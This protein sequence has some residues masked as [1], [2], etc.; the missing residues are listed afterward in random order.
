MWACKFHSSAATAHSH[1]SIVVFCHVPI[2]LHFVP[3]LWFQSSSFQSSQFHTALTWT[4]SVSSSVILQQLL[5]LLVLLLPTGVFLS[6]W[7]SV[8]CALKPSCRGR[9]PGRPDSPA[10]L[11]AGGWSLFWRPSECFANLLLPPSFLTGRFRA[12]LLNT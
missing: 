6:F 11:A 5:R 12:T 9:V 7:P 8:V 10:P 2:V 3:K 4:T 1:R